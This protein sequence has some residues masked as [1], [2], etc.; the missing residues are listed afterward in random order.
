[1]TRACLRGAFAA[2]TALVASA[3]ICG[4]AAAADKRAEAI[5]KDALKKAANDYLATNYDGAVARLQGAIEACGTTH[6]TPG[7]RAALLRDLGTMQ[8]RNGDFGAARKTWSEAL[9]LQQD[10]A[11]NADYDAPDLR[12]AWREAGAVS[13]GP[14]PTGDFAH[15]AAPAQRANTPL[16]IYVEVPGGGEDIVR[17]V[18]KY[19]SA[20][21]PDWSRLELKKL[22]DGW[23]DV[24]PCADVTVGTMRYWIEGFDAK[25]EPVASSG[26][27]KR[28]YLVPIKN[29]ITT[30]PPHLPG[31]GP[32]KSCDEGDC[33]PGLAGCGAKESPASKGKEPAGVDAADTEGEAEAGGGAGEEKPESEG[34]YPRLWLGAALAIDF[35]SVPSGDD[36]CLLEQNAL[37]ANSSNFYCTNPDGSDLPPRTPAGMA[38]NGNFVTPGGA[39]HVDGGTGVGNIRLMISGDYALTP[40]L[41]AGG[42]IGF[43]AG[44]Y[45]GSNA[46]RDG[47]AFGAPVHLEA[48]GTYLLGHRPLAHLGFAPMAFAGLGLSEFDRS[49]SGTVTFRQAPNSPQP[50]D[51]WLTDGPF[52]LAL[53]AGVRY[54]FLPRA[55][56]TAALRLNLAIGGNGVLPTLGPEFGVAYGF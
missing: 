49:S 45:S 19:R 14:Q 7:T 23:G 18:A 15:T 42:R 53:G 32:P 34:R 40:N 25:G 30:A 46:I 28:P 41:L 12:A 38:Q 3:L 21:M 37:P 10:L 6:C 52:F 54:Q 4:P 16:P 1:M 44:A 27:P 20:S 55:A 35:V 11:L 29:E 51:I 31:K 22:G 9:K 26:D 47:R 5:A 36:L 8:F 39:G 33:P 56:A 2:A 13:A 50:V 17:V 43:V 48:R 24:I